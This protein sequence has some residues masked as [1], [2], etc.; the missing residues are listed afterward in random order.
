MPKKITVS[1]KW[2]DP[3]FRKLPMDEKLLFMYLCDVCDCAGFVEFDE[4]I[5]SFHTGA[6]LKGLEGALKGLSPKVVRSGKWLWVVNYIKHQQAFPSKPLNPANKAHIG[7]WRRL[8]EHLD[9]EEVNEFIELL[10]VEVRDGFISA[11]RNETKAPCKPLSRGTGI[12]TGIGKGISKEE[13]GTG[14]EA[15][16][17]RRFKRFIGSHVDC[18]KV[19]DFQ[20]LNSINSWPGADIDE[21]LDAFCRHVAGARRIDFPLQK[22][23]N[24]L[25]QAKK[26]ALE[27]EQVEKKKKS[28]R[29]PALGVGQ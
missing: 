27:T 17:N 24:H 10:D 26:T 22:F 7:I 6:P 11:N 15:E 13:G 23:E 18:S 9:M 21:A 5:V 29:H 14:G 28:R 20:F 2:S 19:K 3:W 16:F 1:E 8:N 4:E 25:A 12:G